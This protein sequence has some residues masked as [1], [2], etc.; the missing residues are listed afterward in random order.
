[1]VRSILMQDILN[2][3]W[4]GRDL[5]VTPC[6]VRCG[7]ACLQCSFCF[8]VFS[9]LLS[10]GA[11]TSSSIGQMCSR[12]VGPLAT[13]SE[14][15]SDAA[16][17]VA[18]IVSST[19]QRALLRFVPLDGVDDT[20]R[21]IVQ[22]R[23]GGCSRF[24]SGQ[25]TC[26][27]SEVSLA[28][29]DLGEGLQRWVFTRVNDSSPSPTPTPTPSPTESTPAPT[30]STPEPIVP[31]PDDIPYS[32]YPSDSKD[33]V[34]NGLGEDIDTSQN[35]ICNALL[36]FVPDGMGGCQCTNGKYVCDDHIC[37][38]NDEL[39]CDGSCV[40]NT[41]DSSCGSTC[42]A[43]EDCTAANAL[44]CDGSCVPNT[45]DSS[46]GTTCDNIDACDTGNG[47]YCDSSN[48][49]CFPAG[50][51]VYLESGET[52][53]MRELVIGDR[54]QAVRPDGS[55]FY[56]DVYMFG[57]KED[58]Q[59]ALFVQIG[60]QSGKE[61]RLTPGHYLPVLRNG[62]RMTIDSVDAE[63]GDLVHVVSTAFHQTNLEPIVAKSIVKD[64]GKFNPY[65]LEGTIVVD[66]VGASV[67]SRSA[68]DEAFERLG[69]SIPVGYQRLFAPLR[70]LYRLLGPGNFSKLESL[71]DSVASMMNGE[72]QRPCHAT[73]LVGSFFAAAVIGWLAKPRRVS[74]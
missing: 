53:E 17:K 41:L 50:S 67:H 52:K 71:I 11:H 61:L 29:E 36:G 55:L 26:S 63:L 54:V 48:V 66:G 40:P 45:L 73:V 51:L 25:S 72:V 19:S 43:L 9:L 44:C 65:L 31:A 58:L 60:T 3:L 8:L 1:M 46:C 59:E 39:C 30:E 13:N 38:N 42:G 33:K 69:I 15:C 10:F 68:L 5:S 28:T 7:E 35:C 32:P 56:D 37:C 6:C 4:V 22:N 18:T 64:V 16:S 47:D 14:T 12:C 23:K 21:I 49:C 74:A 70:V 2:R 24:L 57:H 62:V 20:Y 34:C 27:S